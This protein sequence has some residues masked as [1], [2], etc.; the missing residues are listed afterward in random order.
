[1]KTLTALR[2]A[3]SKAKIISLAI[4]FLIGLSGFNTNNNDKITICHVPPG[5]ADNC[6]EITISKNALQTHLN[7]GDRL[8]CKSEADLAEALKLVDNN[9]SLLIIQY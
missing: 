7:H 8:F 9:Q 4:L 1:M 2:V 5:N 6:H 3:S